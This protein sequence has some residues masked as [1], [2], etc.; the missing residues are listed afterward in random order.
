MKEIK[1]N[2]YKRYG[3]LYAINGSVILLCTKCEKK[4]RENILEQYRTKKTLK[5]LKYIG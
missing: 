2:H 4:L 3:Y 5:D 1:C